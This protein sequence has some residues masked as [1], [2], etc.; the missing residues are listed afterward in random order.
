[1]RLEYVRARGAESCPEEPFFRNV[2]AGHLGGRDPFAPVTPGDA[3]RVALTLRR[4]GRGYGAQFV[5][6]DAAGK[7]L[8]NSTE[9]FDADCTEVVE[10]AGAV[11]VPW[12]LPILPPDAPAPPVLPAPPAPEP[13][14]A[15]QEEAQAPVTEEPVAPPP[16][17]LGE[18]ATSAARK[19]HV[20]EG[21]TGVARAILYGLAAAGL[22]AGTGFAL[23]SDVA[24]GNARNLQGTLLQMAGSFACNHSST[25][26]AGNC[27]QLVGIQ[28][29]RDTF[30]NVGE[31]LLL[32]A[33]ALGVGTTVSI[34]IP[35]SH[36][37]APSLDLRPT[38]LGAPAG[39]TLAGAW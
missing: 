28:Q 17:V 20:F 24:A 35:A 32:A 33:G 8:G 10:T 37:H 3:K 31:G 9:V 21:K 30:A 34:W 39:L 11:I 23:A 5:L 25:G 6:Y 2:V 18:P 26:L 14:P 19:P 13:P 29:Q 1:M 27:Q 22:A 7:R 16:S 36:V 12:L 15:D 38:A 4:A